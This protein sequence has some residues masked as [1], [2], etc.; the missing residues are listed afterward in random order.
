MESHAVGQS[1]NEWG[2]SSRFGF[3]GSDGS[4]WRV[5]KPYLWVSGRTASLP[6]PPHTHQFLHT[7]KALLLKYRPG[8]FKT[9]QPEEAPGKVIS[10]ENTHRAGLS[11]CSAQL[12]RGQERGTSIYLAVIGSFHPS[13]CLVL[14]HP[15]ASLKTGWVW[16]ETQ[17]AD[18]DMGF[19][20][21]C[22]TWATE[23]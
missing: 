23:I 17:L 14:T 12:S 8:L 22:G 5:H 9:K 6:P 3:R 1:W 2:E 13:L 16:R 20:H 19:V 11:I 10:R 7:L 15:R 4:G 18:F 21:F